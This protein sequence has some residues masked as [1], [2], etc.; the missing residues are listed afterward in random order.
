MCEHVWMRDGKE[1]KHRNKS[2]KC[3]CTSWILRVFF[4]LSSSQCCC[5]CFLLLL[6]LLCYCCWCRASSLRVLS[7]LFFRYCFSLI[8]MCHLIFVKQRKNYHR[9]SRNIILSYKNNH[10]QNTVN[11]IGWWMCIRVWVFWGMSRMYYN[12]A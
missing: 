7:S 11:M 3:E 4:F 9:K 1:K 8:L 10:K 6:L 5:C 12:D 2:K